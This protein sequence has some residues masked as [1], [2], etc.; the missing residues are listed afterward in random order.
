MATL[1]SSPLNAKDPVRV[2]FLGG[3]RTGKTAVILKLTDGTSR[4][5]Y[6]PLRK[7]VPVMF[8]F[9]AEDVPLR[10]V[11]DTKHPKQALEF[12]LT[13]PDVVLSPVVM[14]ALAKAASRPPLD[15][16]EVIRNSYYAVSATHIS[17]VLAE[18]IDTPAF[19]AN[20]FVPFLEASLHARLGK[21]IL[22][23]LAD[24]PRQPVNT[25]PL[26][27]ASGAGEMNGAIDGYF[28]CYSAVPLATPPLYGEAAAALQETSLTLLLTIKAGLEEAWKEFHTYR[29]LWEHGKEKDVFSLKS[30][31]R[32]MFDRSEPLPRDVPR[33]GLLDQLIDPAD[34]L[35]PPPIWVLCTHRDLPLASPTLIEDGKKLAKQWRAGFVLL[36][37]HD[38]VDHAMALMVREIAERR[39]LRK[40]RRK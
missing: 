1:F 29:T 24:E 6:Y 38:S 28:L 37:V 23:K 30:A 12:A 26:L 9:I 22:R 11:L 15:A 7:T 3:P 36:D 18:L 14:A 40:S 35:C 4:E 17:P 21:H 8:E 25:E 31:V 34:P 10:L 20:Q 2:A 33:L 27:V 16:E 39:I 32:N 5:T 19:N 13:M